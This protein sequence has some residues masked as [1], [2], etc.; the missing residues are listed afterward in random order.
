MP[1]EFVQPQPFDEAIAKLGDRS[2]VA[3]TLS[4]D[5]WRDVPVALRERIFFSSEV[6]SVRFLQRAKDALR[7]HLAGARDPETGALKTGSRA[8][9][10][11]QM[12]RFA[13]AEGMGPLKPELKGTIK[14]ITSEGRLGLIFD[15]QTKAARDYGNWK[16]GMDP[17]VLDEYPAQ[18][19]IRVR[20]VKKPRAY[21]QAAIGQVRLKTDLAFWL[22]LNR[23][24]GVPWGPWGFNSGCDVEDVDRAETERLGLLKRN[25][26][27]KPV[28]RDFN[29][30]LQ[31]SVAH[32][33]PDLR[34]A[35][36]QSLEG[37]AVLDGDVLRWKGDR[38]KPVSKPEPEPVQPATPAKAATLAEAVQNAGLKDPASAAQM[39]AF[40]DGLREDQPVKVADYV[41]NFSSGI[42]TGSKLLSTFGL[43]K[44]KQ[45][46]KGK[47]LTH[48]QAFMDMIPPSVA[49]GLPKIKWVI[50]NDPTNG[51]TYD[52]TNRVL[53]LSA[54]SLEGASEQAVRTVVWHEL[55]HWLHYH[56]PPEY[57]QAVAD[58]FRARTTLPNGTMEPI[59]QLPGYSAGC[60]GQEDEWYS[61]YAGRRYEPPFDAPLADYGIGS[62][63]PTK[64]V[65]L[66][67]ETPETLAQFWNDPAQR[68]T[69]LVA[70]QAFF[71]T[72]A[73]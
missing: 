27:V 63:V 70:L 4:S 3:S 65:E 17:V 51:G 66:L 24:F 36:V 33:D 55:A 32:L 67:L 37:R 61:A 58:H 7:D 25:Q 28:D 9:F 52:W 47:V 41:E 43:G 50:D 23:D 54:H 40:V 29:D 22:S 15:V 57:R 6:E 11:E 38:A 68:E 31:A 72:S 8:A 45:L 73:P 60:V 2:P 18:R 21:H 30:A 46:T 39:Q 53:T 71:P 13:L 69:L 14:D 12:Q 44:F 42:S 59:H 34:T 56:G 62:E 48:A 5:Q 16:Q 35:L 26:L 20:R 19:F 49:A 10:V 1:V 64:Y